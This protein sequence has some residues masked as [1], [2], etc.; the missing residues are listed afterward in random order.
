[1]QS[2]DFDV[3]AS[4]WSP[5]YNDPMTFLDMWTTNNGNNHTLW[6]NKKYDELINKALVTEDNSARMD[7]MAEAEKLLME[8]MPVGP[9][10]Y[11]NR[12]ALI[13]SN[14][15]DVKISSVGPEY[16]FY[17]ASISK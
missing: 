15:K 10:Y 6:S 4:G 16:D 11:R 3:V 7:V 12:N 8:E 2:H 9:I 5:D 17:W 14:V 13:R 1:M